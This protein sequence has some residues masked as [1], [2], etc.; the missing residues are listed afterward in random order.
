MDRVPCRIYLRRCGLAM[1]I[2]LTGEL[3]FESLW[4]LLVSLANVIVFGGGEVKRFMKSPR[5]SVEQSERDLAESK[6]SRSTT[7]PPKP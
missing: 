2:T 7:G 1:D 3:D 6:S 5:S 4:V